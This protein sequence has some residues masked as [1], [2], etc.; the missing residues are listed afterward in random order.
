MI[1]HIICV[2]R[3]SFLLR[4]QIAL[5]SR[6]DWH[7]WHHEPFVTDAPASLPHGVIMLNLHAQGHPNYMSFPPFPCPTLLRYVHD[8]RGMRGCHGGDTAM[9][10]VY[11]LRMRA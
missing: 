1:Y 11:Q 9:R 2:L 8:I 10:A 7:L 3:P 6:I 5:R 4:A